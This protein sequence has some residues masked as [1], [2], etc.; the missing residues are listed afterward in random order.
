MCLEDIIEIV[1][2]ILIFINSAYQNSF[3]KK[4]KLIKT[5]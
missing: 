2:S 5:V 3:V 1:Y 4:K